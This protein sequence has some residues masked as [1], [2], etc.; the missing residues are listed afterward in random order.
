MSGGSVYFGTVTTYTYKGYVQTYTVPTGVTS[1]KVDAYGA[2]GGK[3]YRYQAYVGDVYIT[4]GY[5]GYLSG[6]LSVT[7]GQTLYV[8]VGG[9]GGTSTLGYNGGGSGI[10]GG[11]GG[12][13][14]FTTGG[15]GGCTDLRTSIGNT[16]SRIFIVGGGGGGG[17]YY[18]G[19]GGGGSLGQDGFTG[20][21]TSSGLFF[22]ITYFYTSKHRRDVI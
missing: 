1:L 17:Q 7:S 11:I 20:V 8:Y 13:S 10:S 2:A 14:Q 19:G 18:N 21:A 12:Q 22:M 5:G 3:G 15:G 6:I 9:V 4:A 16:T